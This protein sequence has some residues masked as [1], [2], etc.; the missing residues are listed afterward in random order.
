MGRARQRLFAIE[1][2][3]ED[4]RRRLHELASRQAFEALQSRSQVKGEI[5]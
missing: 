3:P 5:P 4:R 1:I 2:E